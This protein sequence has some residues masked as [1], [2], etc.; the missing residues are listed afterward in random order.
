MI[1]WALTSAAGHTVVLAIA[2]LGK[3]ARPA[4]GVSWWAIDRLVRAADFPVLFAVDR[5]LQHVPLVPPWA[6]FERLWLAVAI[7][8]FIAYGLLGGALYASLGAAIGYFLQKKAS[9]RQAVP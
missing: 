7:S 9:A 2:V 1:R 3:N 5:L 4:I 6:A 8:E